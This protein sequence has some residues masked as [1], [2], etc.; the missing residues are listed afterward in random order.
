MSGGAVG[1]R[2][3]FHDASCAGDVNLPHAVEVDDAG[4]LGIDDKREMNDGDG[5]NLAQKQVQVAGRFLAAEVEGQEAIHGSGRG[6]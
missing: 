1:L 3:G 4:S 5:L 6:A 2:D